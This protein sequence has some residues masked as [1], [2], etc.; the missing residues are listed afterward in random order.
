MAWTGSAWVLLSFSPF[1]VR[2]PGAD[3]GTAGFD[4]SYISFWVVQSGWSGCGTGNRNKLSSSQAQLGQATY[5][6]VAYSLRFLCASTPSTLY[7]SK[8]QG[9]IHTKMRYTSCQIMLVHKESTTILHGSFHVLQGNQVVA[10]QT[11]LKD[12]VRVLSQ[13]KRDKS[14]QRWPVTD[15]PIHPSSEKRAPIISVR[16]SSQKVQYNKSPLN[17]TEGHLN[18]LEFTVKSVYISHKVPFKY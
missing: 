12:A 11:W 13:G 9:S 14:C 7:T 3:P 5:L 15:L 17:G 8:E 10:T 2:H 1:P 4:A 16:L 6:D 18:M